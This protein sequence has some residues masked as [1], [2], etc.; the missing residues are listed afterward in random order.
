VLPNAENPDPDP[1]SEGLSVG[2][3]EPAVPQD[4]AKFCSPGFGAPAYTLAVTLLAPTR[5]FIMNRNLHF[6]S[7][8]RGPL[9]RGLQVGDYSADIA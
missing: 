1:T 7:R 5:I 9:V 4:R 2:T 6:A 3:P 8:H